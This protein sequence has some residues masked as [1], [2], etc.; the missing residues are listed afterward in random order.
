MVS[1]KHRGSFSKTTKFL[2]HAKS[3]TIYQI[4]R[5]YGELGVSRL[6]SM[7]PVDT[8]D[9]A[10]SWSYKLKVGERS[11][12]ITW[13]NSNFNDGAQIAILIQ[14]GHTTK[15]GG[16]I[17]GRDYINPALRPVFDQ[18]ANEVWKEVVSG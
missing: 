14:Y 1:I 15:N 5:K 13:S 11:A 18:M 16:W 2:T 6:E 17:E 9:T 3:N 4:M 7:T 12:K 8:A 10:H